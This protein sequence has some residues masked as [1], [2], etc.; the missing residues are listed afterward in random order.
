MDRSEVLDIIKKNVQRLSVFDTEEYQYIPL[1]QK[2]SPSILA[3]REI[4]DLLRKV[5]FPGFF[6]SEHEAQSE[7]IQYYTGVNLEKIY[8]L[9]HKQVCNSLCFDSE[10]C[11]ETDNLASGI[12]VA[13]INDIPR[14]KHFLSTDV[15][16]I[17]D[18]D[19][20]VNSVSEIIFSY[21][22]IRAILHQR[23][24]H[25]LYNLEV[26]VLPRIITEIAHSETGIDIH[27]GAQIGKYF[28]ID[29]GTGVVIG[30][31]TIIGDHVRLYQGVTL[32]ARNFTYDDNGLPMDVP[33][34]PIIEDG[35][36]IYSNSSILGRI[37]IGKNSIIGGNIWLTHDVPPNSKI[38]QS[39][40]VFDK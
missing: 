30:Q 11:C 22:A 27:P 1:H 24:A 33:R 9:L 10:K 17:L 37:T 34:H 35:V 12:T 29:H 16:A 14:I 21:P 39:R 15:K 13:F 6:G 28:S 38:L 7:S 19:P 8:D 25:A 23:V 3:V 2:S 36:V 20:A 18:G 31:T 32:G 5:I 26:P 40:A 4:M